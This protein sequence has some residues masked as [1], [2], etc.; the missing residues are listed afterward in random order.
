MVFWHYRHHLEG[1]GSDVQLVFIVLENLTDVLGESGMQLT[2]SQCIAGWIRTF[3]T[4]TGGNSLRFCTLMRLFPRQICQD[5]LVAGWGVVLAQHVGSLSP[6]HIP[7]VFIKWHLA[8]FPKWWLWEGLCLCV[9][10]LL[11]RELWLFPA[12]VGRFKSI[13]Q[14]CFSDC[15]MEMLLFSFST[16]STSLSLC[17][18]MTN[19]KA[20]ASRRGKKWKHICSAICRVSRLTSVQE[21]LGWVHVAMSWVSLQPVCRFLLNSIWFYFFHHL[22][23]GAATFSGWMDPFTVPSGNVFYFPGACILDL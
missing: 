23:M 5:S 20:F 2:G 16:C 22:Q 1:D 9:P 14:S 12:Q 21:E 11:H 10:V 13:Q 19:L 6:W 18:S 4:T 3:W 15:A 17:C 8:V 7:Y